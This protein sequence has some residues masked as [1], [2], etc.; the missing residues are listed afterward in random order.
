LP[1][2]ST[3]ATEATL[4]PPSVPRR[5]SASAASA[6][7]EAPV[8]LSAS[9]VSER[10]KE[11]EPALSQPPPSDS[12]F[13]RASK[14]ARFSPHARSIASFV[15]GSAAFLLGAIFHVGLV[16]F[17]LGVVGLL[18]GILGWRSSAQ[19]LER[20]ALAATGP[21]VNLAA[22][23]VTVLFPSL[24]GLSP[25]WSGERAA[26][27][28][29]NAVISLSGQ[30]GFRD[31]PEGE[32]SWVDASRD[33]LHHGDVRVRILSVIVGR[34]DLQSIGG[35]LPQG[36]D[37]AMIRLRITNAGVTRKIAYTSWGDLGPE[38]APLLHDNQGKS[39]PMR[40]F[41]PAAVVKGHV[42]NATIPSMKFLE[43]V[44]VFEAPPSSIAFLHLDLPASA[45]GT[46]GRLRFEIPRTMI[47]FR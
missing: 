28:G 13:A 32:S 19:N 31:V 5:E 46:E 16:T 45:A 34:V 39:Y 20:P 18:V 25:L 3:P 22:V 8:S 41:D 1:T 42:K 4:A 29:E 9:A 26:P 11:Q 38:D 44:L 6:V 17:A 15:V 30:G 7:V 10:A 23:I 47:F 2:L 37:G 40:K 33:A 36:Q 21:I 14:K 35:D 12:D 27:R 43:D 24:L